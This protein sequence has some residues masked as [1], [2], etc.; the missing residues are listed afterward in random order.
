MAKAM[1]AGT[2]WPWVCSQGPEGDAKAA[3]GVRQRPWGSGQGGRGDAA[4]ALGAMPRWPWGCGQGP[5]ALVT[6]PL[7]WLRPQGLGHAPT[8]VAK[9]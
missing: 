4:K 1:G 5:T 3:M 6:P 8:A 9:C 2:R 7:P